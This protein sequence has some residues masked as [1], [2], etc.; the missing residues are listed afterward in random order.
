MGVE[1]FQRARPGFAISCHYFTKR[2][3]LWGF[4][5]GALQAIQLRSEAVGFHSF[6]AQSQ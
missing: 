2:L 3:R 1:G 6:T 5:P 4:H